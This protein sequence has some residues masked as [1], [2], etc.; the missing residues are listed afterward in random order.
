MFPFQRISALTPWPAGETSEEAVASERRATNLELFLDLVFVFTVTQVTSFIAHDLT[1]AGLGKGLLL[2]WLAWWQWTAFTW[3][4]SAVDLEANSRARIMVLCM[5][6]AVLVMAITAP[7]SFTTQPI[8][9]AGAYLLVQLWVLAI[10]W[11]DA[12]RDPERISTFFRYAPFAASAPAVLFAG[13]F[14]SPPVRIIVWTIA[15]MM[16][17]ISALLGGRRTAR[18]AV[19]PTHFSE[20]HA[21][22]VIITLGE[23]LV[24]IGANGASRSAGPGLDVRTVA[25]IVVAVSVA[26][27]IWWTYFALV[28]RVFET[29]LERSVQSRGQMARNVGSF[30]HF[31]LICAIVGYAI[32]A[33]HV[34]TD[35]GRPLG[36]AM[37]VALG[38]IG[39]LMYGSLLWIQWTVMRRLSPEKMLAIPAFV[40]IA[41]A[42]GV[43][44]SIA[45]VG[46]I[47]VVIGAVATISWH[48]FQR[49][50]AAEPADGR[51]ST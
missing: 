37:Q 38:E 16:L 42:S 10:Q 50:V 12:R 33:E 19:E 15:A 8:W 32:V 28:P 13:A 49:S 34:V 43:V 35:P 5:V 25:A 24:A 3:A 26:C 23:V 11:A 51:H 17:V 1:W 39:V 18:W 9:F 4:G 22:F 47:S 30:G 41:L 48:R 45:S 36:V 14:L 40:L 27:G 46:A 7:Q 44:P 31:P 2:A 29:A 20:R 6:P 21:L